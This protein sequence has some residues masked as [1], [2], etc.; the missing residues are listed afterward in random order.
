[1][2]E[3][4]TVVVNA[5]LNSKS[6]VQAATLLEIKYRIAN[7]KLQ[8]QWKLNKARVG[9]PKQK[10][11]NRLTCFINNVHA[12]SAVPESGLEELIEIK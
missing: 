11:H 8:P 4:V 6:H 7:H 12:V 5:T 1:M 3:D 2:P 10:L 9:K